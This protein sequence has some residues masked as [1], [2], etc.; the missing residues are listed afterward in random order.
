[1][2]GLT[3]VLTLE[4]LSERSNAAGVDL[5]PYKAILCTVKDQE[6][7]GADIALLEGEDQRKE[8][9]RF[10]IAARE[11][12]ILLR[13]KASQEEGVL[14]FTT[15]PPRPMKRHTPTAPT[16]PRTRAPRTRSSEQSAA[17]S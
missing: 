1:M 2:P 14:R 12:G 7:G 4:E 15:L 5:S 13:W 11:L 6:A 8:K 10:S 17:V 16:A 3:K 9:R